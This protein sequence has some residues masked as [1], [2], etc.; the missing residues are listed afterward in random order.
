[1]TSSPFGQTWSNSNTKLWKAIRT[2]QLDMTKRKPGSTHIELSIKHNSWV[3][4]DLRKGRWK[5]ISVDGTQETDAHCTSCV[6]CKVLSGMVEPPCT[7]VIRSVRKF[8]MHRYHSG[9]SLGLEVNSEISSVLITVNTTA[10]K[11]NNDVTMEQ[12]GQS[13]G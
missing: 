7:T 4:R 5:I 12:R 11:Q 13:D 8:T 9:G 3:L 1:M 10:W 6:F 2:W